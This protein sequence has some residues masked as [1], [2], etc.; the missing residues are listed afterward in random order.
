[1]Q[2]KPLDERINSVL[3]GAIKWKKNSWKVKWNVIAALCKSEDQLCTRAYDVLA[4]NLIKRKILSYS[5]EG[6]YDLFIM[7]DMPFGKLRDEN[8]KELFFTKSEYAEA[9]KDLVFPSQQRYYRTGP[10]Q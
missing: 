8:G 3:D 9:Y 1:M 5:R 10:A 2:K 6:N 4:N 7:H